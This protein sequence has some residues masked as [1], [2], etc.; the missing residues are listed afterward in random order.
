MCF[1]TFFLKTGLVTLPI[2]S[3]LPAFP[4]SYHARSLTY[5][6]WVS[7]IAPGN[8]YFTLPCFCSFVLVVDPCQTLDAAVAGALPLVLFFFSP[9][10][11]NQSVLESCTLSDGFHAIVKI[12]LLKYKEM[13]AWPE[14][15]VFI[16]DFGT[17]F[18]VSETLYRKEEKKMT[19]SLSYVWSTKVLRRESY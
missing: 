13:N 8:L 4:N 15:L 1:K 10:T 7:F 16:F 2:Q 6:S 3:C 12:F 17:T 9:E 5:F 11:A 14:M 19:Y 18:A